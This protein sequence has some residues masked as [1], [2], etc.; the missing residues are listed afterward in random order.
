MYGIKRTQIIDEE[1][2][3]YIIDR[4]KNIVNKRKNKQN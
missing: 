1:R 4:K 2:L 3:N